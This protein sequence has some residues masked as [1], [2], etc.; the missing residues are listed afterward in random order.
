MRS[1]F[2]FDDQC[3]KGTET[4]TARPP[5]PSDGREPSTLA[6]VE[7][8]AQGQ[9]A[10]TASRLCTSQPRRAGETEQKR[11]RRGITA[12]ALH[13]AQR[14]SHRQQTELSQAEQDRSEQ[15]G[16]PAQPA[17]AGRTQRRATP[18]GANSSKQHRMLKSLQNLSAVDA[19]DV[20]VGHPLKRILTSI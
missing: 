14:R 10:S 11:R 9:A 4:E 15:T 18:T 2:C 12:E 6:R 3:S 7:Y 13:W 19:L 5:P 17:P 16:R 1:A 8:Q 20:L